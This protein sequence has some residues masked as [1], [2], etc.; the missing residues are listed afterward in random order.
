MQ[1][2]QARRRRR[3]WQRFWHSRLATD[4]HTH[5]CAYTARDARCRDVAGTTRNLFLSLSHS[6]PLFIFPCLTFDFPPS[7]TQM[8]R[9]SIS[10]CGIRCA[11]CPR[12][13]T[14]RERERVSGRSRRSD[15]RKRG[16]RER[17]VPLPLLT[18]VRRVPATHSTLLPL[19]ARSS[20]G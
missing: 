5:A 15:H 16:I 19:L 11:S 20:E 1:R 17:A 7:V 3:R 6:F 18:S 2:L 4:T 14:R 10:G 8:E 12:L 13:A 9:C